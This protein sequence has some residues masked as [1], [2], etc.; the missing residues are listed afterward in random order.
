M[1]KGWFKVPGVRPDGDRTLEE[2]LI[3]LKPALEECKG[4][5]VLDLGCAE[6][7]ISIEFAKAGALSVTGIEAVQTHL[8]VAKKLCKPYPI[9]LINANLTAY[10]PN[11]DPI[12]Q[13]DI[14]LMLGIAH[15][16]QFPVLCVEFAAKS[17]KDLV[18]FRGPAYA[19]NGVIRSK[20]NL[21]NE[22][23]VPETMRKHGFVEE[24]TIQG[25]RGESVQYWRRNKC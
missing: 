19:R 24:I 15:K 4:K 2:Q 17:A 1:D 10:I 12:Q 22:C 25:V 5:T 18:L 3:G 23:D 21:S 11:Q 8:D 7:L 9:K 20:H 16:L 13:Y 6:A 14:V